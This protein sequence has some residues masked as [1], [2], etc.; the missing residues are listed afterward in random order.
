MVA[1]PT[2]IACAAW[3]DRLKACEVPS[4]NSEW[5][6]RMLASWSAGEGV[7]PEYM[8]LSQRGF[9]QMLATCFPGVICLGNAPSGR[10]NDP[11]KAQERRDLRTW[12]FGYAAYQDEEAD[13]V[14]SLFTAGCLGQGVLWRD[15]G[16]WS[17]QDL[18][19]LIELNFPALFELDSRQLRWKTYFYQRMSGITGC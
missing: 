19:Y 14:S 15:L 2:D 13:W 18:S 7:L 12:L 11:A 8:G 17:V 9:K 10:T 1:L 4:R 6:A 5:L 16:L 3:Y